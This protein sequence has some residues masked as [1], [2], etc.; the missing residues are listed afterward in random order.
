MDR[1]ISRKE[2]LRAAPIL[3]GGCKTHDPPREEIIMNR[4]PA[5]DVAFTPS[6]KAAQTRMGS[7][8]AYERMERGEGWETE[9][10][11]E[12]RAFLAERD[13]LYLGT[14][15]AEGQPYIQ[16]RGGPRGFVQVLDDKTLG[17]ADLAGNR[18]Y[19]TV[20]NLAEND[21]AFLFFMDYARRRRIKIW[22]RARI[23][24]GS[25]RRA[26]RGPEVPNVDDDAALVRRLT[27]PGVSARVERA[28]LFTVE[29][30]D[31]NCPQHIPQKLDAAEV[32]DALGALER[33]V[34]ELE[35]ENA[36]LRARAPAA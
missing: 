16:H 3:H 35:A 14:A 13:S 2:V 26:A 9:V 17:M 5:S 21:R 20:G 12:L 31:A 36:A 19:V 8:A 6:V 25:G 23:V 32:R 29:A 18:Q 7:R 30:W 1:F 24:E 4:H 10:T 22:G 33:R 34:A 15:S 11:P 27:P 28:I